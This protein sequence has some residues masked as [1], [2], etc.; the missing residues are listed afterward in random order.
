MKP[1]TPIEIATDV[2]RVRLKAIRDG[3][4]DRLRQYE[5][6]W[7]VLWRNA[8]AADAIV[9]AKRRDALWRVK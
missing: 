2:A 3:R 6:T 4:D 9:A 1:P 8:K 7:D 5:Q